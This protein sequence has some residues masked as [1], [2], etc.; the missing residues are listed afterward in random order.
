MLKKERE[1]VLEFLQKQDALEFVTNISEEK[2]TVSDKEYSSAI[3]KVADLEFAISFL[4][5]HYQDKRGFAFAFM[6]KKEVFSESRVEEIVKQFNYEEVV[7]KS[8][9]LETS[10]NQIKNEL[11]EIERTKATLSSLAKLEID[12]SELRKKEALFFFVADIKSKEYQLLQDELYSQ[13]NEV[14]FLAVNSDEVNTSF[15]LLGHSDMKAEVF[16]VLRK[17]ELQEL[18]IP[19]DCA[20]VTDYLKRLEELSLDLKKKAESLQ[21]SVSKLAFELP[22]VK[23]CHDYFQWEKDRYENMLKSYQ[24]EYTLILDAWVYADRLKKLQIELEQVTQGAATIEEIG[25]EEGEEI[26]VE[27]KNSKLVEP[28]EQVTRLYGLPKS[29]EPDPTPHLAAFFFIFFGFCL[30]DAIYG[31]ILMCLSFFALRF[32]KVPRD[33]APMLKLIGLGGLGTLIMGVLFGGYAGTTLN[34]LPTLSALQVF[35]FNKG[36]NT[37]MIFAFVLGFFQLWIGTLIA[38]F[39]EWNNG[40]KKLAFFNHFSWTLVFIL[41]GVSYLVEDELLASHIRYFTI[42]FLMY[43]LSYETTGLK[44]LVKAPI[45]LAENAID[46][47]SKTMSYARL[48]ALGLS[49]GVIAVVFNSIAKLLGGMFPMGL[50]YIVMLLIILFGHIMNIAMNSL[51][52]FIHSARLQ[53]V[54][55]FS[56]FME[57]GGKKFNPLTRRSSYVYLDDE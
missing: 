47:L 19:S 30:T 55:F 14:D 38:G 42:L 25:I 52:A 48:F 22:R 8:Q 12:F 7:S 41:L 23:A 46:W 57:G 2:G 9:Q 17:Y 53:F 39:H 27:I 5:P 3:K 51:G 15:L 40:D 33:I 4:S 45:A 29:N 43:A 21:K 16:K 56:K 28:F 10:Q 37:V 54:E 36:L 1:R 13:V 44:K 6:G 24:T 11:A 34:E 20:K 32:M 35:D 31:V 49:T 18:E 50:N 26:P